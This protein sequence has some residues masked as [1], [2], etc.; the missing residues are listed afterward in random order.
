MA[1]P[2]R[3]DLRAFAL[4]GTV[5]YA[6]IHSWGGNPDSLALMVS[7]DHRIYFRFADSTIDPI[8]TGLLMTEER[9]TARDELLAWLDTKAGKTL[10]RDA[11]GASTA[12][13]DVHGQIHQREQPIAPSEGAGFPHYADPPAKLHAGEFPAWLSG[14]FVRYLDLRPKYEATLARLAA[15]HPAHYQVYVEHVHGGKRLVDIA[16]SLGITT[17]NAKVRMHRA[18]QFLRAEL[19]DERP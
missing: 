1:S 3:G 2:R 8:E 15:R 12:S 17:G 10:V 18:R 19:E 6:L 4:R 9:D 7:T 14:R 11:R 13:I 16:G 5:H